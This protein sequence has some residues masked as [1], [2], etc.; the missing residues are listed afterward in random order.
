MLYWLRIQFTYDANAVLRYNSLLHKYI[1]GCLLYIA[2]VAMYVLY[3]YVYKKQELTVRLD[4]MSAL[5]IGEN[6]LAVHMCWVQDII[7]FYLLTHESINRT[8]I[9]S[10]GKILFY[11]N[12]SMCFFC[13]FSGQHFT[14][15]DRLLYEL[16]ER[17]AYYFFE[18]DWTCRRLMNKL[19]TRRNSSKLYLNSK[20]R[21]VYPRCLKYNNQNLSI[22]KRFEWS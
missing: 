12:L 11:E 21:N 6:K 8:V 3:L 1:V 2:C 15:V 19:E 13:F 17:E 10:Y 7:V 16:A 5:Y 20:N 22:S 18:A 14:L 4:R 9:G